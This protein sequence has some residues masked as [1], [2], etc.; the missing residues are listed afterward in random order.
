MG[1]NLMKDLGFDETSRDVMNARAAAAIYSEVV[2]ELVACR[3]DAG[4]SQK[5]LAKLMRTSQSTVSEFES[6]SSDARFSTLIRYAQAVQCELVI[7]ITP[8]SRVR[9]GEWVRL[10][11]KPENVIPFPTGHNHLARGRAGRSGA[12]LVGGF[13]SYVVEAAR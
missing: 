9:L 12:K 6:A 13:N 4:M 5:A 2:D 7:E 1:I 8:P 10:E 11:R 3:D